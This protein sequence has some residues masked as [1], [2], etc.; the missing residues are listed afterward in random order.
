MLQKFFLMFRSRQG[1][2][3]RR[4]S[5]EKAP[6]AVPR[7]GAIASWLE[8]HGRLEDSDVSGGSVGGKRTDNNAYEVRAEQ[9]AGRSGTSFYTAGKTGNFGEVSMNILKDLAALIKTEEGQKALPILATAVTNVAANPTLINLEA[10]GGSFLA[11]LIAAEIAIGQ[12][13]L[14]A[15]AVDV[16]ALAAQNA[17]APVPTVVAAAAAAAAK[18][19]SGPVGPA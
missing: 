19:V 14:K 7:L 12:D 2:E 5:S 15:I 8:R 1:Q 11:Q 18:P 16:T 4:E 3:S 13:S 10:Q 17:A 6:D 9:S